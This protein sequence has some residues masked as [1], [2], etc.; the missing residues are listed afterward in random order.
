MFTTKSPEFDMLKELVEPEKRE[1]ENHGVKGG[2]SKLSDVASPDTRLREHYAVQL[3]ASQIRNTA[4]MKL[5]HT[6]KLPYP[7]SVSKR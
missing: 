5:M 6:R 7:T 3:V 1:Q 4:K 2:K